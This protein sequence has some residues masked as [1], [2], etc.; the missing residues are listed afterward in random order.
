MP[1]VQPEPEQQ[2]WASMKEEEEQI[3]VAVAQRL[4][5][6]S[7]TVSWVVGTLEQRVQPMEEQSV[8]ME[9][10]ERVVARVEVVQRVVEMQT[11]A[12][13]PETLWRVLLDSV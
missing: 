1:W 3:Q 4:E 9:Q 13:E 11:V 6:H 8:Q 5:L 7:N 12:W 2:V 10:A